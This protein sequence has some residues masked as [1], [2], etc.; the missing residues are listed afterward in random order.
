MNTDEE[1]DEGGDGDDEEW[2]EG[3][4][5]GDEEWGKMMNALEKGIKWESGVWR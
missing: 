2:D 3:G 1:W 4:D 5:E